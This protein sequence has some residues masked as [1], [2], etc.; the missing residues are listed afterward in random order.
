MVSKAKINWQNARDK[1][2]LSDKKGFDWLANDLGNIVSRQAISKRAKAEKWAKLNGSSKVAQPSKATKKQPE[3][4]K[5]LTDKERVLPVLPCEVDPD[6][7]SNSGR[8]TLYKPIYAVQAEAFCILGSDNEMLAEMFEVSLSTIH[9][10]RNKY[11][12]FSDAIKGGKIAA[13][14][15]VASSLFKTAIGANY[16][17]EER[18][19]SDGQGG[20]EK[21]VLRKQ[22]SPSV[23]AQI[24]WL[25][26]RQPK[27]WKDKVEFQ[28]DINLNVFPPKEVLDAIYSKAL[29][30][31]AKR[32]QLLLG[33]RE[34][35][36]GSI[37][38][39]DFD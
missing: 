38:H 22:D 23:T 5:K 21:V 14:A 19:V 31:A 9:E 16:T 30:E 6:K 11:P 34:R 3:K 36:L 29:E 2:E 35:L 24:F 13:D 1:W 12:E 27:F 18:M 26:N 4:K 15:Q 8:P 33:R 39:N 25:K 32:D 28:Q 7:K 10:W 37:E 20:T 17:E